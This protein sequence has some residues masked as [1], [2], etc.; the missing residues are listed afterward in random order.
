[1]E[2]D[3]TLDR[4]A[5]DANGWECASC[6]Y[7]VHSPHVYT[8]YTVL[9]RTLATMYTAVSNNVQPTAAGTLRTGQVASLTSS[10]TPLSSELTWY[11]TSQPS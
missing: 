5:D 9:M 4:S 11:A 6:V 1:M 7:N 8:M 10:G 3:W 2:P